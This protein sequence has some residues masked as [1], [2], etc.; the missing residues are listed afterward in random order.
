MWS[1]LNNRKGILLK[2]ITDEILNVYIL[3][4]SSLKE[5]KI[6]EIENHLTKCKDCKKYY[7]DLKLFYSDLN[8]LK[9]SNKYSHELKS[10][11]TESDDNNVMSLAAK[12]AEKDR[13]GYKYF[14]TY[15]TAEKLIL[16][17]A[18]RN[19]S[20]GDFNLYLICENVEKIKNALVNIDGID[21]DFVSN[22]EGL[23]NIK[24]HSLDKHK[25]INIHSSIARFEIGEIKKTEDTQEFLCIQ[26]S[27]MKL[28]L[29]SIKSNIKSEIDITPNFESKKLKA[30]VFLGP[31]FYK[32]FEI[33][34]K[35]FT[36]TKPPS[37]KF[38]IIIVEV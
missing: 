3:N 27:G 14:N 33:L 2:H 12:N 13:D 30:I 6:E 8:N 10:L 25:K 35:K 29:K 24:D 15:A 31:M 4:S 19:N 21:E 26:K 16:I 28:K 36:F 18:F 9:N 38:E 17:R 20:T 34:N 32:V 23:I 22:K 37:D 5:N 7:K 11:Y 1:I